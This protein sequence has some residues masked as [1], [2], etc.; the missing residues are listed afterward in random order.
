[1]VLELV[2]EEMI[3]K[4]QTEQ[5][6]WMNLKKMKNKL[7]LKWIFFFFLALSPAIFEVKQRFHL[8]RAY[9]KKSSTS[10]NLKWYW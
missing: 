1:M 10:N 6:D 3:T 9:K 2:K 8:Y 7:S 4:W 5:R